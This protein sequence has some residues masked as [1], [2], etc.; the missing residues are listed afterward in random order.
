MEMKKLHT[1][2]V[3]AAELSFSR[4]A[5]RM[6]CAQSSV[7]AQIQQLEQDLGSGCSN[8]EGNGASG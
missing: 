8:G 5:V 3:L 4:T 7:T 2:H 1:F 6:S